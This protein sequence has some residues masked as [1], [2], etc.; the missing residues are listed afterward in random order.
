[1]IKMREHE[2]RP[3]CYELS[4]TVMGEHLPLD[5]LRLELTP[6]CFYLLPYHHLEMVKFESSRECDTISLTF[7][8][9]QV[10]IVGRSLRVIAEALQERAVRYVEPMP[11]RY[12]MIAE[13]TPKIESIKIEERKSYAQSKRSVAEG[14]ESFSEVKR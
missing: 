9:H 2:D 12:E 8:D 10:A 5:S 14:D 13:N 7:V 4:R 1:M 3:K 6:I 11:K